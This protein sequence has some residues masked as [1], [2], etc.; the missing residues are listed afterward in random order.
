MASR[1]I[2]STPF[3]QITT[4]N[5]SR[6]LLAQRWKHNVCASNIS[7][8]TAGTPFAIWNRVQSSS[9]IDYIIRQ[10]F[11]SSADS[12][13]DETKDGTAD[14]NEDTSSEN[15]TGKSKTTSD[16]RDTINRFKGSGQSAENNSSD[17]AASQNDV[18]NSFQGYFNTFVDEV[19]ET[20]VEL[21]ESG[22]PKGIN[23]R[24]H[25][26]VNKKKKKN[27]SVD[28]YDGTLELMIIDENENL[29]AW[30][31]M[32]RRLSEAPIIQDI[33]GKSNEFYEKSGARKA[34]EKLDD[35]KEDAQEAWETSQNPWVYRVSSVYDTLTAESDMAIVTR[36]L[37]KLDPQFTL[38][39]FKTDAVGH[40]IP[41]IMKKFLDGRISELEPWLG[42]SVYKRLTA[43]NKVRKD[44][45]LVIDSN[46]LGIFNSDIVAVELDKVEKQ[47][48]IIMHYMAQQ[49]NCVRNKDGEVVEGREDDIKANSYLMAFQ[50]DYDE[51]EGTLNWKIVDFRFNGAIAWL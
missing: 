32:Q 40:T 31:K 3:K 43:E 46:L 14:T 21:V 28:Q 23:K 37:Q 38:E 36:E 26:S 33:L 12:K 16:L 45:G 18:V 2:L 48:V 6:S 44:E 47:P 8:S 29:G 22:K 15:K 5:Q 34:K 9:K 1:Y 27:E 20:W 49:I 13:K 11:S 42:E 17:G 19:K 24:L 50:R 41:E 51:E 25:D 30:E 39:Q 35:I 4:K 7:R 10:P